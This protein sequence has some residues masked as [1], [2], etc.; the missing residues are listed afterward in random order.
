MDPLSA[1][2]VAASV[3]QFVSFT[4]DVVRLIYDA[5]RA[6]SGQLPQHETIKQETNKLLGLNNSIQRILRL[7]TLGRPRTDVEEALNSVCNDCHTKTKALM[8]GLAELEVEP[9]PLKTGG[10]H[11][12]PKGQSGQVKT[13]VHWRH[14]QQV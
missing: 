5:S 2:S 8:T 6:T 7:D 14:V 3:V 10:K 1:L 13:R 11:G 4:S 12:R 9:P